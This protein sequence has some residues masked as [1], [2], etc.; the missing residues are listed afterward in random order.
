MVKAIVGFIKK[1][2]PQ[3]NNDKMGKISIQYEMPGFELVTTLSSVS[4]YN[5]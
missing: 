1:G 3:F 4:S 5:H 2:L